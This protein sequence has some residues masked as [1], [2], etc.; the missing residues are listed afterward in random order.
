MRAP[1]VVEPELF[2][3]TDDSDDEVPVASNDTEPTA[4][5][6]L[7]GQ[8]EMAARATDEDEMDEDDDFADLE[9]WLKK[10]GVKIVG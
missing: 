7:S 4:G 5:V 10:G 6:S 8:T 2:L 3:P 1:K 9:R